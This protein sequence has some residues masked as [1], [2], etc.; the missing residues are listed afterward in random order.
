MVHDVIVIGSGL[1]GLV[2]AAKL[3]KEGKSVLVV[4]QHSSIGGY[5]TC[6]IRS[7]FTIDVGLHFMD[8]LYLQ[9]PKIKVFED[10]DVYFNVEFI[11]TTNEFY[12]FTDSAIDIR[13]P[14]TIDEA[15]DVLTKEFPEEEKG[16]Q[17][18]FKLIENASFSKWSGKSAGEMLD[19]F[20]TNNTIKLILTGT[21]Q[22]YGDDP[23]KVSAKAFVVAL[24]RNFKGGNHYIKGGSLKLTDYL[25][26]FIR[27]HNG[28]IVLNKKVTKI[29]VNSLGSVTGVEYVST[30]NESTITTQADAKNIVVNASI[31]QVAYE[32]LPDNETTQQLRDVVNH[33]KVGHSVLN[34]YFGFNTT[35]DKLGHRDYLTVVNDPTV[36]KLSDIFGNNNTGYSRKNFVF[37][38]YGRIESGMAPFGKSTGLIST[39]D[40][41][42][43]WDKLTE[44]EY[45]SKKKDV[46]VN[47]IER[48]DK[49]IPGVKNHIEFVSVATPK[50]MKKYTHNPKGAI[51]G[52]ARTP[53][54]VD[55]YPF[56]S[57]IE[58]LY[59][60]SSWSI[61]DGGF[62]SLI[63]AGW[64][65]ATSILRK[66]R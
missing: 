42:E 35:L 37:V 59:F 19:S 46:E 27:E 40:Y 34:I 51:I 43:N 47:L 30:E 38:N 39:I 66:R 62:T 10:L 23:Y 41:I 52:F 61:P 12:R 29:L 32:L 56:N 15:V 5:A 2:A 14:D 8:G 21:I 20:F 58:N 3:A 65:C 25:A 60:S 63:E 64:N 11:K 16:I 33:L 28:K 18:F 49:L 7:N 24:S 13:I 44:E 48:L 53:A 50:T 1:G 4:E 6:F 57:P 36:K 31:P 55:M 54:Q 26:N 22:Y 17:A 9:D 45:A